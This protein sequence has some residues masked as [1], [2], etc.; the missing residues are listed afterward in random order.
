MLGI[1]TEKGQIKANMKQAFLQKSAFC[2]TRQN[3]LI[4]VVFACILA[5]GLA[6]AVSSVAYADDVSEAQ[7]ALDDA[8]EQMQGITDEYNSLQGD[9]DKLQTKIDKTSKKVLKAQDAVTEGRADLGKTAVYQY[10]N[11]TTASLINL[12]LSSEDFDGFL[13][14]YSYLESVLDYQ[15][16]QVT[17]QQERV[18][19]FE[20]AADELNG[21]K[22][23]QEEKLKKLDNKK[24]EAQNVVDEASTQ[25]KDA[26][27]AE[28]Q[29][30]AELQ[31][32]AQRLSNEEADAQ[33][34][35]G[36]DDQAVPDS[37]QSEDNAKSSDSGSSKSSSASSSSNSGS[38]NSS[39]KSSGSSSSQKKSSGSSSSSGWKSGLA[40]GYGG[41]TDA[42]LPDNQHTAT[43]AKI[44]D[45]S[46]GVA[47]P[48]SWSNYSSY[49]GRTIEIKYN[50][51]TVYGTIN[52]CGYM[53]GGYVSLDLQPGIFKAFGY[54]S[55]NAWGSRT[56]QYRIL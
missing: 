22:S 13:R 3:R 47:I 2:K 20:S 1:G 19:K 40:T 29:R 41:S 18:K 26:K 27:D 15:N 55:C 11:D 34:A 53:G 17:E 50:G 42:S 21:Q 8:E 14:N 23:E 5:C 37:P 31:E 46:T 4:Q 52:D 24:A 44:T 39:S 12:V 56:V 10:R 51:K 54:N 28:A 33:S 9:I 25:L 36:N 48:M 49:Y 30:L 6:V 7:A 32:E 43:G 35:A 45:S 16:N 38:S